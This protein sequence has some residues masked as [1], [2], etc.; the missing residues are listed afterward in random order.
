MSTHT[1]IIVTKADGIATIT[2]NRPDKMNAY[3]RTMGEEII[4]AMDDIDADDGLRAVIFTGAGERAF[5]A[6]ADLTPDG[7]GQ[8]F[9]AAISAGRLTKPVAA[10]VCG[11]SSNRPTTSIRSPGRTV[12]WRCLMRTNTMVSIHWSSEAQKGQVSTGVFDSTKKSESTFRCGAM[13]PC[14]VTRLPS[15]CLAT[16]ENA[17]RSL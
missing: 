1:Q 13:K 9:A 17:S 12:S 14:I 16:S 7:G 6:G 8:V 11:P 15:S 2:L 4:A 5:C 3:T 10:S